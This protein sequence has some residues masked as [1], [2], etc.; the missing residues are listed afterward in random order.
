LKHHNQIINRLIPSIVKRIAPSQ[1]WVQRH[2][3]KS[4]TD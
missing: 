4:N 3:F 2:P 1:D